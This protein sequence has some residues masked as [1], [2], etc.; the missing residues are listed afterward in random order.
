MRPST[1][2]VYAFNDQD[3]KDS[4]SKRTAARNGGLGVFSSG[5]RQVRSR[6]LDVCGKLAEPRWRSLRLD[7]ASLNARKMASA[8]RRGEAL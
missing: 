5:K 2:R 1:T 4:L 7:V 8:C 6:T 3:R